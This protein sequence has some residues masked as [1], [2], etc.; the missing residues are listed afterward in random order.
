MEIV[1]KLKRIEEAQAAFDKVK[2]ARD[3]RKTRSDQSKRDEVEHDPDKW[4]CPKCVDSR[5]IEGKEA[6][7]DLYNASTRDRCWKCSTPRPTQ[8]ATTE[9]EN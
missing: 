7:R 6:R 8:R 5:P 2:G 9:C 4:A 3:R 1:E